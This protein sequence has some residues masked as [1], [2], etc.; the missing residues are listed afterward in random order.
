MTSEGRVL[1]SSLFIF[2]QNS[3]A[4]ATLTRQKQVLSPIPKPHDE[5]HTS[6]CATPNENTRFS[7]SIEIRQFLPFRT[8]DGNTQ[9]LR[10]YRGAAMNVV[11]LVIIGVV[12]FLGLIGLRSGLLRPISGTG[13]LIIG[14]LLAKQHNAEVA[15]MLADYIEG[16]LPHRVAAFGGIVIASATVARLVA[17]MVKKVLNTLVLGWVDHVAGAAGSAA[18]SLVLAGTGTFLLTGADLDPTGDA[19]AASKLAPEVFRATVLTSDQPWCSEVESGVVGTNCTD[20]TG[21]LNDYFGERISA[22][23]TKSH[24]RRCRLPCRGCPVHAQRQFHRRHNQSLG[25]RRCVGPLR[26]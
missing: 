11:D 8:P 23:V 26:R 4:T 19:L 14:V 20:R 10:K 17:W 25:F 7:A 9:E 13:G 6:L 15:L 12:A 22:Q 5:R 21:L 16:E 2:T 18:L 3:H 24:W 1:C